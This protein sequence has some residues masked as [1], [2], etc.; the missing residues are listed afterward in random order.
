VNEEVKNTPSK[1][2]EKNNEMEV[3]GEGGGERANGK[4]SSREGNTEAAEV[5]QASDLWVNALLGT[6]HI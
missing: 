5:D 6:L 1:V 4:T 2:M 3:E